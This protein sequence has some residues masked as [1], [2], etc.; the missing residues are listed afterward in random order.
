MDNL[1][2]H[3]GLWNTK[4]TICL[5]RCTKYMAH[6]KIQQCFKMPSIQRKLWTILLRGSFSK[7][8]EPYF[9]SIKTKVT[10]HKIYFTGTNEIKYKFKKSKEQECGFEKFNQLYTEN[11][12]KTCSDILV[13]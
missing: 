10:T 4:H 12:G 1:K 11:F 3:D 5:Y 9:H 8:F 2:E 6:M 13:F 7:S